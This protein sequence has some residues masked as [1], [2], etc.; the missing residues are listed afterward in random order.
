MCVCASPDGAGGAV[1]A[2]DWWQMVSLLSLCSVMTGWRSQSCHMQRTPTWPHTHTHTH[3]SDDSLP[4]H[5]NHTSSL[6]ALVSQVQ[7]SFTQR[8]CFS[9][10][11]CDM[12]HSDMLRIHSGK[13][14]H[15]GSKRGEKIRLSVTSWFS[16]LTLVNALTQ[17]FI[18]VD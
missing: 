2:V 16:L 3:T 11:V 5:D 6:Q 9:N 18:N 15:K 7:V 4:L 1:W 8:M 10:I 14:W 17:A 12:H 13:D